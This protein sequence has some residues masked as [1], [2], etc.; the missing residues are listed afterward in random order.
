MKKGKIIAIV[1]LIV[2]L[3]GGAA[4]YFLG[5]D[6]FQGFIRMNLTRVFSSGMTADE[7]YSEIADVHQDYYPGEYEDSS[8]CKVGASD[9]YCYITENFIF[10]EKGATYLEPND[11]VNRMYAAFAVGSAFGLGEYVEEEVYQTAYY[12]DTDGKGMQYVSDVGVLAELGIPS[13]K[14]KWNSNGWPTTKFY[15]LNKMTSGRLSYWLNNV[16]DFLDNLNCVLVEPSADFVADEVAAEND[17]VVA[18]FDVSSEEDVFVG[19]VHV[20]CLTA[21][22]YDF[23]GHSFYL[24]YEGGLIAETEADCEGLTLEL[25]DPIF[26]PGG[27]T[28]VFELSYDMDLD[29]PGADQTDHWFQVR[30]KD[31]KGVFADGTEW[32][33]DYCNDHTIYGPQLSFEAL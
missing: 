26:I 17:Q 10:G 21:T 8:D 3:A 13:V 4:G 14:P 32:D 6:N 24:R 9:G 22:T 27:E 31:W 12:V 1:V 5:G 19:E 29:Y 16:E 23:D 33:S 28:G 20:G 7:L 30:T 25:G 2:V 18:V 11:A 15:P